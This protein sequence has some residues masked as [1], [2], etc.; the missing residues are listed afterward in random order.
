MEDPVEPDTA[1]SF[2]MVLSDLS[3]SELPLV[4][5]SVTLFLLVIS[6][7]VSGSE[8][9]FF[10][11]SNEQLKTCE[12]K[13]D[14]TDKNILSLLGNPKLLLATI[15]ILN[16]LV[17]VAIVTISAYA[18]WQI[19]DML[20]I[21][22]TSPSVIFLQTIV[23]TAAI[24]FFGEIVPKLYA[25]QQN[26]T[27][28]RLTAKMLSVSMSILKPFSWLLTVVGN[29]LE[30]RLEGN[31]SN[32]ALSVNELNEAVEIIT[33]DEQNDNAEEILKGVVNFSGKMVTQ[34]MKSRMDLTAVDIETNFHELMGIINDSGFSR[35]PIYQD[36]ID[37]IKGILYIKD[38]LPYLDKGEDFDWQ[39]LIRSE[40]F[41]IPESKRLDELL[42]D[43]QSRR[44]HMAIIVDE[45]GGTT[46]LVTLE[47]V[48]EEI[49]GEINDEFD[50]AEPSYYKKLDQFTFMF[51]AKT[52][53]SDFC[54]TVDLPM[55]IFED[56]RGD[57]ESLG[58]LILELFKKMPLSGEEIE[59]SN[60]VFTVGNVTKKRIKS[61]KVFFKEKA[62]A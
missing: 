22:R 7:L 27:F 24:V 55:D 25:S 40:V 49:V 14:A 13:G 42:R 51:D 26:L 32:M 57:S 54:K 39:E 16:N 31:Q 53:L 44:V 8:V 19:A 50:E 1:H 2:L 41:F 46:G 52:S 36:T 37:K 34:I 18:T 61:V 28:A 38:L 6:A 15:L 9:A 21:S 35:I 11:L 60:I 20:E 59:F 17:N 12:E 10:S 33:E 62:T 29:R 58:G 45:Y 4:A 3:F 56:A 48:I 47:D 30:K 5:I 23:V 43:F